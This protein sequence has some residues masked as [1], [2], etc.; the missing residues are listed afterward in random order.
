[1]GGQIMISVSPKELHQLLKDK[2]IEYLFFSCTVR[3]ACTMLQSNT[4]MSLLQLSLNQLPM[5]NV[6]DPTL[7]K[8]TCMWNKIQFYIQNLHGY[9]PRQNKLGPVCFK[10]SVDFLSEI[11]ERDLYISKRNPLNWK[12]KL[13]TS[14]ICYSSVSEF[15]EV[16]DSLYNDKIVH[17]NIILIRDK[18]SQINLSKYLTE[19][20]LDNLENR[21]LLFKKAEKALI[22]SLESS[23]LKNVKLKINK[24]E[25]FCFCQTNYD[26]MQVNEIEKLFLP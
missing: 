17:K 6:D 20:S 12:K 2:G 18:K 10:I 11:H 22:T 25:N 24:C 26:E 21:H 14:D 5:T 15:S 8:C 7:Y 4:L 16:F 1:M 3:N 19:I 9:F 13:Q 23:D